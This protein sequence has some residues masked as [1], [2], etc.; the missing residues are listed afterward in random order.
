M[1]VCVGINPLDFLPAHNSLLGKNPIFLVYVLH[2]FPGIKSNLDSWIDWI[3][4]SQVNFA[5]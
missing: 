2:L 1:V 3:R 4:K 5:W